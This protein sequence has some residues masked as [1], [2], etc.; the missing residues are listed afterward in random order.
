MNSS[1]FTNEPLRV[2]FCTC[3]SIYSTIV[4]EELIKSP[5]LQLV[6]IVAS[7]RIF[8][9][10]GWNWWDIVLLIRQTGLRYAAYLWMITSLYTLIRY[11]RKQDQVEEYRELNQIPILETRDINC[12]T[13]SDFVQACNPDLMLSAHFNQLIGPKLLALPPKGCLNIHPGQLPEY[14]GVDPVIH[15]VARGEQQLGVTVHFQDHEFDTGPVLVSGHVSVKDK[16]SLFSLNK[17]LFRL[18]ICLL[19]DEIATSGNISSGF[20]Q[21]TSASYD[22]WPDS[23]VVA[24]ARRN[25]KRLITWG[26]L[27]PDRCI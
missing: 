17:Q 5:H 23:T 12:A 13:S 11:F 19:L 4:L 1:P 9:K 25:G 26:H 27:Y 10:K 2:V 8:R 22:S 20:P 16:D 18:G 15:A 24:T 7:T 6:G 21:K 14:K 3:P